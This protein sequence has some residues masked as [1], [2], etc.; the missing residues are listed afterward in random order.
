MAR[1]PL[2][3][4]ESGLTVPRD[5]PRTAENGS[6]FGSRRPTGV[7]GIAQNPIVAGY[8]LVVGRRINSA[9]R[10]WGVV[11]HLPGRYWSGPG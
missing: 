5:A 2:H 9:I 1:R 11:R 3:L 8:K 4:A 10:I 6:R 7:V